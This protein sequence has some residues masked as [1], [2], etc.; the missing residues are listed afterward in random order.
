MW[1]W[2]DYLILHKKCPSLELIHKDT[3]VTVNQYQIHLLPLWKVTTVK[4]PD[5]V[6]LPPICHFQEVLWVICLR[7]PQWL[8]RSAVRSSHNSVQQPV[9]QEVRILSKWPQQFQVTFLL[10]AHSFR[11]GG[12]VILVFIALHHNLHIL[13]F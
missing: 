1:T 9:R 13:G 5:L 11:Y 4:S 8:H 12:I 3:L 10:L 7:I 2:V 6:S